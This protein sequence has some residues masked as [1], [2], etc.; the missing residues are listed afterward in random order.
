M[1]GFQAR[2][3]GPKLTFEEFMS[4]CGERGGDPLVAI[5]DVLRDNPVRGIDP[6][7][8]P[9]GNVFQVLAKLSQSGEWKLVMDIT[10]S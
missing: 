1:F 3:N 6:D 5:R 10:I 4:K 7:R 2:T 9:A 8:L